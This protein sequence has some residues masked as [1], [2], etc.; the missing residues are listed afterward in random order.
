M[1]SG[2]L[3]HWDSQT[4]GLSNRHQDSWMD[5]LPLIGELLLDGNGNEWNRMKSNQTK[6][7]KMSRVN[8]SYRMGA[9]NRR[10]IDW[11]ITQKSKQTYGSRGGK[12]VRL[13]LIS[14]TLLSL[15]SLT[16]RWQLKFNFC[17][18]IKSDKW[19]HISQAARSARE[20]VK[21]AKTPHTKRKKR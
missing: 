20:R 2:T 13:H 5:R 8:E 16:F 1:T 12:G 15:F 9:P 17:S 18:K 21:K 7:N 14:L 3:R 19:P 6:W 4:V 11:K 10:Q